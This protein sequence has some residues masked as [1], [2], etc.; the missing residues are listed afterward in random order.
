MTSPPEVG[1]RSPHIGRLLPPQLDILGLVDDGRDVVV[2]AA[3]KDPAAGECAGAPGQAA[4]APRPVRTQVHVQAAGLEKPVAL[5]KMIERAGIPRARPATRSSDGATC[6]KPVKII[7]KRSYG[8]GAGK[9]QRGNY[10]RIFFRY[11][12]DHHRVNIARGTPLTAAEKAF[13]APFFPRRL[14][15]KVR[16][17]EKS[18]RTGAFSHTA[19]A[20]TYGN[21]LIIVRKGRRT[22]QLMKHE[23]VHVCQYD[24]LGTEGFAHE[25]ANQYVESN[26]TYKLMS[27][28]QDA[29]QFA[30]H[31][32]GPISGYLGASSS[33]GALYAACKD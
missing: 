4:G 18:G 16:I 19:S 26:Y 22:H 25:Y 17:V 14:I 15:D 24:K 28:E 10:Q 5:E 33:R 8:R 3:H 6:R 1:W 31:H 27:F 30:D 29:K 11:I 20:T 32:T 21:D 12:R 13:L 7:F 9:L 23:M 2:G